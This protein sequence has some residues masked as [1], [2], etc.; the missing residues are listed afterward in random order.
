M[1]PTEVEH[2]FFFECTGEKTE[3]KYDGKF[4]IKTALTNAEMVEVA[5][6]TDRYNGGSTTIPANYALANRATAELEMRIVRDKEGKLAAPSWFIDSDFCRSLFDPNVIY[7]LFS[8]V[9]EEGNTAWKKRIDAA[10]EKS[11]GNKKKKEKVE[12]TEE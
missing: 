8:K 12:K 6:R 9:L 4:T 3:H 5:L 7:E 1:L 11:E 2:T 10:T